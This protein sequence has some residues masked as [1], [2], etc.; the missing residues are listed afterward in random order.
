LHKAINLRGRALDPCAGTGTLA[1]EAMSFSDGKLQVRT[2]DICSAHSR[3]HGGLDGYVDAFTL[4]I[5][6]GN[7]DMLLF[8]P[9]FLMTD[10]YCVWAV[11][12]PVHLVIMLV[13]GDYFTNAP[14]YRSEFLR[15]FEQDERL[16][17][18]NGL[19]LVPGR[20]MRRCIFMVLFLT[21]GS[22][23]AFMRADGYCTVYHNKL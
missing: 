18:I 21:R 14:S 12:Q 15:P 11:A 13:A 19:P 3:K 4:N 6:H 20:K 2:N 9:P 10:T 1:R 8:S 16:M 23:R 22:K 7:I 17:F 5:P